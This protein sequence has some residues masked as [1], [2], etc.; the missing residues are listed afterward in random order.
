MIEVLAKL[1]IESGLDP[2]SFQPCGNDEGIFRGEV[3]GGRVME[4][5]V[6]I[7]N[8]ATQTKYWPIIRG[9]PD[10]VHELRQGDAASILAAVPSG[11][12]NKILQSRFEERRNSLQEMVPQFATAANMYELAAMADDSGIYSFSG[13]GQDLPQ[14]PSEPAH[15]GRV[16]LHTLKGRGKNPSVLLLVRVEH[17]YD[18]PA[19]LEFGGWNDCP[20]PELQ[21]AALREWRKEYGV[22]PAAITGDV[23]ECVVIKDRPKTEAQSM[24]LAAEQ[25]IFCE[26]I[27]GQGTQSVR[28]LAMDLWDSPTWFF[29][30][31]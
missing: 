6:K 7:A 13:H 23:L 22:R 16:K 14:W 19:H 12:I 17:S 25:W 3:Q 28:K 30:W 21:V 11:T 29:W 24:K 26:D 15:Q 18:I 5:W 31:D 10:D 27:V 9:D 8:G 20:A 1:L 4:T 2:D